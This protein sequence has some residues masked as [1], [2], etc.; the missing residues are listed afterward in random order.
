MP[1]YRFNPCMK[2]E[3][4][5]IS[6]VEQ[7]TLITNRVLRVGPPGPLFF[8]INMAIR[9]EYQDVTEEARNLDA[10]AV[11]QIRFST[12]MVKN[13]RLIATSVMPSW[14]PFITVTKLLVAS[15]GSTHQ[16]WY[17]KL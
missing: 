1:W 8:V 17:L 7:D 9:E 14:A 11:V 13:A 10:H 12:S 2:A 4:G 5:Y 16:G 6:F 3:I 15:C